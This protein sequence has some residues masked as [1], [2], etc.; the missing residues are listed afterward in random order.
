MSDKRRSVNVGQ[1]GHHNSASAHPDVIN[2]IIKSTRQQMSALCRMLGGKAKF[3]SNGH[4]DALKEL[5]AELF[6]LLAAVT[7]IVSPGKKEEA[8]SG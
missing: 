4:M 5:N 2:E 8:H 3:E 7:K 1:S 6:A